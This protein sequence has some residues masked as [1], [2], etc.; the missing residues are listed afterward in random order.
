[1]FIVK[2]G[3]SSNP[4]RRPNNLLRGSGEKMSNNNAWFTEEC[5]QDIA[6]TLQKL[7]E[8][9]DRC[10]LEELK[11]FRSCWDKDAMREAA[12]RLPIESKKRLLEMVKDLDNLE[13]SEKLIVFRSPQSVP[14]YG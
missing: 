5:L 11:V 1:M 6:S 9:T 12:K 13:K 3:D 2:L 8:V 4:P 10:P 14:L 7:A